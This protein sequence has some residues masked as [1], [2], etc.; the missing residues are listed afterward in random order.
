VDCQRGPLAYSQLEAQQRSTGTGNIALLN[1]TNVL[2]VQPVTAIR[3]LAPA[4]AAAA[5]AAA[6]TA[7]SASDRRC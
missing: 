2:M 7:G 4:A 5:A 3:V 1:A 6:A